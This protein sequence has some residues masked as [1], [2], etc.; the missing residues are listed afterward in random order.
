MTKPLDRIDRKI[1]R[2]LLENGRLSNT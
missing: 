2:A 1:L